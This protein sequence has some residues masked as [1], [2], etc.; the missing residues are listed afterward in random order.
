MNTLVILRQL[1]LPEFIRASRNRVYINGILLYSL[2]IKTRSL[3]CAR[4]KA[5]SAPTLATCGGKDILP[6][7]CAFSSQGKSNGGEILFPRLPSRGALRSAP[8]LLSLDAVHSFIPFTRT[9][10]YTHIYS[11]VQYPVHI[12]ILYYY[13]H[14]CSS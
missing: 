9:H 12:I 6:S 4:L 7:S 8:A 2:Y 13:T 10:I 5:R 1:M 3:R 14:D 11:S